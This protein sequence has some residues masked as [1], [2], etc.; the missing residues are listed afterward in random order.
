[1]MRLG[2]VR[3]MALDT[4]GS[5]T[6]AF[7]GALLNRPSDG[8]ERAI[9]T[10][11][12]LVYSG[13][14]ALPPKVS[15]L[16]P[17]GDGADDVQHLSYR[18]VRPSN[19]TVTLV[20]PDRTI[21][22]QQTS[23]EEPGTHTVAFPPA[24]STGASGVAEGAWTFTAS[25]TNDQGVTSSAT[26]RFVV[27][28]TIGYLRVTPPVVALPPRGRQIRISWRQSRAARV[29]VRVETMQGVLLRRL[30]NASF[31]AGLHAVTWNGIRKDG[32]RAFGGTYRVVAT[33]ANAIG[34]VSLERLLRLHRVSR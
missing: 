31:G 15:V 12:L 2:A 13:V 6:L 28:S 22:L 4:G 27:N 7:D 3:A 23:A 21:A 10:A 24:A 8:R 16:S 32:K 19:V 18:V 26:R 34:S 29:T 11:L 1:M 14:Y 9:A 17:N 25:A 5:T 30:A 20:A 33:A